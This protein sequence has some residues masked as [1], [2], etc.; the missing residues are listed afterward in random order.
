MPDQTMQEWYAVRVKSNRERVTADALKGK[1]FEV[2]LPFYPLPGTRGSK[3]RPA[4][5]PLFPGYVFSRFDVLKR[6]PILTI[7][8]VVNIVGIGR[9]PQAIEAEEM[10]RIFAIR[11]SGLVATPFPYP[12]VGERIQLQTGPLRGLE[13]VVVSS[14]GEDKL[15]VS[16]S[17]LQRS[18][19]VRVERE[20][21][22][23]DRTSVFAGAG[24]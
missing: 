6:L 23:P 16:V 12:P 14:K 5:A 10:E 15:V 1:G 24:V 17:L 2:F 19:A 8:G 13:G 22:V 9:T 11:D 18:V 4:E 20:W 21:I 7:P 3:N